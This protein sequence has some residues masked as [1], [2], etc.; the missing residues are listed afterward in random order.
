MHISEGFGDCV[1]RG[2]EEN[3]TMPRDGYLLTIAAAPVS[4]VPRTAVLV[5]IFITQ[6]KLS[7]KDR[8]NQAG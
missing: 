7:T 2:M 4:P 1:T 8:S 3:R 5:T 6:V